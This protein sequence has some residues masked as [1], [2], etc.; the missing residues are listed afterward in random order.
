MLEAR[1][2]PSAEIKVARIGLTGP[3]SRPPASPTPSIVFRPFLRAAAAAAASRRSAR[4]NVPWS[5]RHEWGVKSPLL[6]K[7][8]VAI[9]A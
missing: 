4:R 2:Q 7:L 6:I 9:S 5:G 8:P 3:A 1:L